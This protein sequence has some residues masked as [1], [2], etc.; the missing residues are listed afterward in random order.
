MAQPA[1]RSIFSASGNSHKGRRKLPKRPKKPKVSSSLRVWEN[2]GKRLA[3]WQKKLNKI[4]ADRKRKQQ[5]ID[6]YR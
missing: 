6:K 2:Y 3:D 5:I 1:M 4:Q